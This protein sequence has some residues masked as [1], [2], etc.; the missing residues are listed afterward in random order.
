MIDSKLEELY[1]EI[2]FEG[3]EAK[4]AVAQMKQAFIDAGYIHTPIKPDTKRIYAPTIEDERR[5]FM[6]GQEWYSRFEKALK[7]SSFKYDEGLSEHF[8]RHIVAKIL[9]IAKGVK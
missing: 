7:A 8:Y 5:T 9:E 6:T 2:V 4:E 1:D 3:L